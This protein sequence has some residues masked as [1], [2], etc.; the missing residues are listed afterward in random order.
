[1][2][3]STVFSVSRN[4]STINFRRRQTPS[5]SPS[6]HRSIRPKCRA[7]TDPPS[8]PRSFL[9]RT[10]SSRTL[11]PPISSHPPPRFSSIV[12]PLVHATLRRAC[13][14]FD[15]SRTPPNTTNFSR[16]ATRAALR[17]RF[18]LATPLTIDKSTTTT[19]RPLPTN[20]E[21]NCSSR[22]SSSYQPSM[23]L[24]FFLFILFLSL[25]FQS[26]DLCFFLHAVLSICLSIL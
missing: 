25:H 3:A 4:E 16:A 8:S 1:M 18:H 6:S 11:P 20:H 23:P 24:C 2:L 14:L 17:A 9:P 10:P 26:F 22:Y 13:S 15:Y 21:S 12:Y 5:N 7:R 19:N